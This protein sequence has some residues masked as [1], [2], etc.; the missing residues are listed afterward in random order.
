MTDTITRDTIASHRQLDVQ[1][2][3]KDDNGRTFTG[4]GVP[5]GETID[6]WGIRERFEP[7]SVERDPD[8]VPSLVLWRHDEPIGKI[9]A[10][11]D[12]AAGYEIDGQLSDTERGREAA[13]LLRDGVITR[14]SIGFRPEQYRIEV[15]EDDGTETVVHERVRASEFSLVPFPAYSTATVTKVRHRTAPTD[16][17]T[18][19][20]PAMSDTTLTRADLEPI[21]T[22]L[23][24]LERQIA[25]IDLSRDSGPAVPHFRS[26]GEYL[27]AIARGDEY[28]HDFH[29]ATAGQTSDD[30]IKNETYIGEFV[31]FVQDRRRLI[32]TFDKGAL[33]ADGMRVEYA[34]LASN[35]M[36]A[37]EQLAEGDDLAGPG[38]VILE[39]MS[40]PIRTF[41]GWTE[42]TRQVVER[43]S[44]AYLDTAL[45]AL[46][47]EYIKSTNA[48]F[49]ARILEVITAQA[50][51]AIELPTTPGVYD[52]RD[53]IIDAADQYESNG[54]ALEGL[55][56]SKDKFKELQRLEYTNVPALKV[57]A[58][59]EFSGT[60]T[61][62]RG[63]GNLASVPVQTMFGEVPAGTASFYDSSALQTR[64]NPNAP[65]QLQDE[66][67]IN[68]TKQY[69]LY[70]YMAVT[71]PFPGAIV[72]V[73]TAAA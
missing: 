10:G 56:V 4:I 28:A 45:R 6:L 14:L 32:N 62:P 11:R 52:W 38:K 31:K 70:G 5:Y 64:E 15:N 9:T 7:G 1:I 21:E 71:V 46:A 2:R 26:M 29:R 65:T 24:D 36:T 63:D 55:L 12:T 22:G 50:G 66:N 42:L 59:D 17:T 19:G 41:G 43:S 35:T 8:G 23:Q 48:A 67:I 30:T 68:L 44:I 39:A 47:L 33:P 53:A 49:R 72:P 13:T 51:S 34:Q 73:T 27:K 16:P 3:A 60:L 37:G 69:S 61:L 18:E 25:G 58:T 57:N 54:F 40:E 20:D